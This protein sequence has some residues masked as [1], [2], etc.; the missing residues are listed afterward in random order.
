MLQ[1]RIRHPTIHNI[2]QNLVLRLLA[3]VAL[4]TIVWEN[5]EL[6]LNSGS[7]PGTAPNSNGSHILQKTSLKT[8]T[9]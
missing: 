4:A 3:K 2:E 7:I 5:G 9:C 6:I 8:E 1:L